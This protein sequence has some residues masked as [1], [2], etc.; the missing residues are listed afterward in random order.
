MKDSTMVKA[1]FYMAIAAL[2]LCV[3]F[4]V[5]TVFAWLNITPEMVGETAYAWFFVAL[6]FLM[7]A[8]GFG[9]GFAVRHL[10]ARSSAR[11]AQAEHDAALAAAERDRDEKVA[12]AEKERD[13]K[14]AVA[15]KERDE[16]ADKVRAQREEIAQGKV[17]IAKL[18]TE[19]ATDR[20]L[21]VD[22]V[23]K[24][25]AEELAKE[26]FR[27]LWTDR[28]SKIGPLTWGELAGSE[29]DAAQ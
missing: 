2:V 18:E 16:L 25:I 13:E 6:P 14:V 26:D 5:V 11:K 8:W 28:G 23:R 12:A 19:L 15:E 21:S 4:G 29:D 1:S 17:H 10:V 27:K 20:G 3:V 7:A 24:A 22:E 9:F